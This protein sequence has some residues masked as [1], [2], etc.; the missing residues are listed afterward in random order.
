MSHARSRWI[1]V[2]AIIALIAV[3]AA[4]LRYVSSHVALSATVGGVVIVLMIA[5]HLGL[6]AALLR[7]LRTDKDTPTGTGR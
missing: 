7:A 6:F 2:G 5:K 4:A 1:I 3:H